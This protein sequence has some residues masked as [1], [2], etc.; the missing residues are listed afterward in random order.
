MIH[1]MGQKM[2]ASWKLTA[3]QAFGILVL[4]CP[5]VILVLIVATNMGNSLVAVAGLVLVAI[6]QGL[7]HVL[8]KITAQKLGSPI[9]PW[10]LWAAAALTTWSV[11]AGLLIVGQHFNKVDDGLSDSAFILPLAIVAAVAVGCSCVALG[12]VAVIINRLMNTSS[13]RP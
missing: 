3:R 9:L 8:A 1:L 7:L 4:A 6:T 10:S 2:E 5:L 13:S 11:L 12:L